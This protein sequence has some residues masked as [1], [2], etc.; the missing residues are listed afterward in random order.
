MGEGEQR[1]EMTVFLR[2]NCAVLQPRLE[3]NVFPADL[4][5][6]HASLVGGNLRENKNTAVTFAEKFGPRA[7]TV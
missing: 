5:H 7:F 6:L 3:F 4:V 1:S 2:L